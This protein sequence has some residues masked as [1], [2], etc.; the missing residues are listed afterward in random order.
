MEGRGQLALL[1]KH[2]GLGGG[3][4]GRRKGNQRGEARG[5]LPLVPSRTCIWHSLRLS[6]KGRANLDN[7]SSYV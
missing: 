7:T 2:G 6:Q 3:A 1:G 4:A 5:P